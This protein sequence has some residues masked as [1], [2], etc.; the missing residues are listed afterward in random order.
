MIKLVKEQM[1]V[2]KLT[3]KSVQKTLND[4]SQNELIL[5]TGLRDIINFVN[6]ENGEIKQKYTYTSMLVMLNEHANQLQRALEVRGD[7]I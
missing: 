7:T 3:F 5:E 6:E 2:V 4:V 1:V